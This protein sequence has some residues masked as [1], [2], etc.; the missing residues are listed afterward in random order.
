MAS[1]GPSACGTRCS[2]LG[3]EP[4]PAR[5]CMA[6]VVPARIR[7]HKAGAA[8]TPCP[9]CATPTAGPAFD[10]SPQPPIRAVT[11]S[12]GF[13]AHVESVAKRWV[14]SPAFAKL[15]PGEAAT[16]CRFDHG[17]G[18]NGTIIEPAR[19][20]AVNLSTPAEQSLNHKPAH[21]RAPIPPEPSLPSCRVRELDLGT[22]TARQLTIWVVFTAA[23][24]GAILGS[25]WCAGGT[26]GVPATTAGNAAGQ[27]HLHGINKLRLA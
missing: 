1:A 26:G 25:G 18:P 3:R 27:L 24:P 4:H 6:K 12:G 14:A 13:A 2:G 9:G 19:H 22:G 5:I 17:I 7:Q 23:M 11:S 10:I 16:P 8:Q 15:L 21:G 20:Q